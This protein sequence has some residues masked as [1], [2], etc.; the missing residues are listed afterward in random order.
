VRLFELAYCCRLYGCLTGFD[1]TLNQLRHRTAPGLDLHLPE[2]RAALFQWLNSWGCRQFAKDHHAT[3]A[4]GSLVRWSDAWLDKLPPPGVH[5]T[6]LSV[7][8][9]ELAL[10][11][12]DALR[13]S[14]ASQ[15]RLGTDS[16]ADVTFGPT[17][18]AKTLFALRPEVFPPWDDPIRVHGGYGADASGLL[19]Y[20]LDVARS[21]HELSAEAGVPVPALPEIVG[22]PSSSPPKLIDE[23]NWVVVTRGCPPPT[24]DEIAQWAR[25]AS[26]V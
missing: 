7:P 1:D 3:T 9:L 10:G 12:Y 11:A 14:V 2:H 13:V 20:M 16:S 18:A 5:L 15:R 22:R 4:S 26:R 24:T 8:E 23:Y 6:E 25:W 17:G 19:G 21:L